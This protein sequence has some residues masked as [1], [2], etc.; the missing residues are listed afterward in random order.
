[1]IS[2]KQLEANR[3]NAL[4]STGPKTEEGKSRSRMNALCHGL[5][6]A[7]A[8]LPHENEDD[9][10]KLREGILESYAPENSADQALVEELVHAYWRLLR[11]HRVETQYWD[12]LGGSYNRADEGIAEALLQT[13]D[14]QMRNFF[15]YYAQVEHSY[16][17]ALAAANQIKRE[18]RDRKPLKALAA[19][20]ENGFVSQNAGDA[21]PPAE[22]RAAK[23]LPSPEHPAEG[24]V[25]L[26]PKSA[27]LAR[28]PNTT[29]EQAN[30]H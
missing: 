26:N 1:M 8:V 10:E 17:R 7:Q 28:V 14:R 20:A 3:R 5:T 29:P 23:P 13:P 15:R 24:Q 4:K 21:P 9:Y 19:T 6:A 30:V 12:H 22:I 2:E 11:M 18:R 25:E 27:P 16:Y